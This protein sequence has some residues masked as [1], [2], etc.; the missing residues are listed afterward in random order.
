[1]GWPCCP[2]TAPTPEPEA[3]VSSVKGLEKSGKL[4]TGAVVIACLSLLNA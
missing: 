4:N 3:S 2:R 1:M